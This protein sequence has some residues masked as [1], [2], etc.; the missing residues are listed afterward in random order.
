M[1]GIDYVDGKT[2]IA[3]YLKGESTEGVAAGP[4]ERGRKAEKYWGRMGKKC[5]H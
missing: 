3:L 1:L 5:L 4:D 2:M